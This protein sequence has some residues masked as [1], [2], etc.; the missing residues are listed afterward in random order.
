M[1]KSFIIFLISAILIG[2]FSPLL[3]IAPKANAQWFVTIVGSLPV[4]LISEQAV[5]TAAGTF[6]SKVVDQGLKILLEMLRKK[7]LDYFVDSIIKWIQGTDSKPAFVTNWRE[8]MGDVVG[9]AVGSYIETTKFAGLCDTF[10]FQVRVS[11]PQTNSRPSLPTCTLNQIVGNIENFY[12]DFRSGGWLAYDESLFPQNN[13]YGSYIIAME[14]AAYE[15]ITAK[16]EKE[17][18]MSQSTGGFENTKRCAIEVTDPLTQEKKCLMWESTTPGTTISQRLQK[19][20]DVDIDNILSATEFTTYVGAILD[21]AINRLFRAGKDGLLGILTK[22]NPEELGTEGPTDMNYE[23][24][25]DIGACILKVGGAFTSKP[26]C[27]I[28]CAKTSGVKYACDTKS[29]TCMISPYGTYDSKDACDKGC[30]KGECNTE[31]QQCNQKDIYVRG[32]KCDFGSCAVVGTNNPD[33]G[34]CDI[35]CGHMKDVMYP[36]ETALHSW[37]WDDTTDNGI[38]S[39]VC[40]YAGVPV[41][42]SCSCAISN[43]G[44]ACF[45]GIPKS[46]CGNPLTDKYPEY[47]KGLL[48]CIGAKPPFCEN[49]TEPTEPV[50]SSCADCNDMYVRGRIGGG[51]ACSAG[52][53]CPVCT[54]TRNSKGGGTAGACAAFCLNTKEELWGAEGLA[55][56]TTVPKVILDRF[57]KLFE[58]FGVA[59]PNSCRCQRPI[60]NSSFGIDD[61]SKGYDCYD[62]TNVDVDISKFKADFGFDISY[63]GQF[64]ACSG[65]SWC[66]ANCA[67]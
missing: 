40:N 61:N 4:Q 35:F 25:K 8:F 62:C 42:S 52:G 3:F 19:A 29:L 16:E 32:Q 33:S 38:I 64:S 55:A 58:Q 50:L 39:T 20:L 67:D 7:L 66:D 21:A 31:P 47:D 27:D 56:A 11:L 12:S 36:R 5:Q 15:A 44:G 26:E 37:E 6:I 10:D 41:E 24:D 63:A 65:S 1:K 30:V 59:V 34:C 57:Y 2:N 54:G 9:D 53:T 17:Q 49:P 51:K 22:E 28:D 14:G 45:T 43:M 48:I 13:P 23:C 46:Q 18:E 60:D